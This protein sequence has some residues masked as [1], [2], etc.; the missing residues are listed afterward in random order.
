METKKINNKILNK[1]KNMQDVHRKSWR[2]MVF[3][4]VRAKKE[5]SFFNTPVK[6]EGLL[7]AIFDE[8][9]KLRREPNDF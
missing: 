7:N 1:E 9:Q 8:K 6:E 4:E 2:I 3:P 5:G